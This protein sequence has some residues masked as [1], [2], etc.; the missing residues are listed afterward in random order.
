MFS[1]CIVLK[2]LAK[3]QDLPFFTDFP[4]AVI[5][6]GFYIQIFEYAWLMPQTVKY[7]KIRIRREE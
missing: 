2:H 1:S 4:Q 5:I 3:W 7:K 6:R